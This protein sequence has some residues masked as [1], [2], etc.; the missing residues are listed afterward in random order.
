MI[1]PLFLSLFWEKPGLSVFHF[2]LHV[3]WKAWR[4]MLPLSWTV[5]QSI[6][7]GNRPNLQIPQCTCL[8]PQC[9]IHNRNVCI[10]VLNSALWDMG[11]VHCGICEM[12]LFL[13]HNACSTAADGPALQPQ[14]SGGGASSQGR[15]HPV[16]QCHYELVSSP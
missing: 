14:L 15:P 6:L 8:I 12:G 16:V 9:T 11:Q 2:F 7:P 10:S 3:K 5:K 4:W 13:S 1:H